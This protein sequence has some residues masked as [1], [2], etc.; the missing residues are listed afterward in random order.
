[1]VDQALKIGATVPIQ[2]WLDREKPALEGEWLY[3]PLDYD[4]GRRKF[5]PLV[6]KG[7]GER[8]CLLWKVDP[9]TKPLTDSWPGPARSWTEVSRF[10]SRHSNSQFALFRGFEYSKQKKRRGGGRRN[11]D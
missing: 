2:N 4:P 9:L 5:I 1:M 7:H 10:Y 6:I 11:E 3:Y 8:V